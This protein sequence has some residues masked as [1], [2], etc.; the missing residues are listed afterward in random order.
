MKKMKTLYPFSHVGGNL[1]SPTRTLRGIGNPR[2]LAPLVCFVFTALTLTSCGDILDATPDGRLSSDDIYADPELTATQFST[3]FNY[4]P[5][6]GNRGCYFW[7]NGFWA[8]ADEGWETGEGLADWLPS[9]IN[10]KSNSSNF[11]FNGRPDN[12][13]DGNYWNFYW[14]QIHVIN[15]FLEHI[16]TA[17]VAVESNRDLWHAEALTLRAFFYLQLLKYYGALPIVTEVIPLSYDYSDMRKAPFKECAEQVISDCNEAIAI[18]A[19]PW[20]LTNYEQRMRMTAGIATAIKSQMALF[21]ASPLFNE[22]EDLWQW[23][24]DINKQ[25]LNDLKAHDYELYT[26]LTDPQ[27]FK[28]AYQ[29]LNG[30]RADLS[31]SPRDKETIWQSYFEDGAQ[32]VNGFPSNNCFKAGVVP[33]QEL[34]DAYDMLATGK[35]VLKLDKPYLDEKHLQ[36]NYEED[37]GY[38]PDN[39]YAGRDP[40]LFADVLY[41]GHECYYGPDHTPYKIETYVGGQDQI[42]EVA[43]GGKNT[44][45]GYYKYKTHHP[46]ALPENGEANGCV[47]W[48]RLAE[49]Y[50]N[51]AE[52][53]VE[54]GHIDEA[55]QLVNDIRHR[56][57]FSPSVDIPSTLSKEE[58]RLRVHHERQVELSFQEVRYI[59]TRRWCKPGQENLTEK[60]KTGMRIRKKDDGTF[61]YERFDL[62]VGTEDAPQPTQ[63]TYQPKYLLFPIP[64]SEAT[65]M[66]AV[67]GENWQNPGW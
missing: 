52:C 53:A 30:L 50:L 47:K 5:R 6:G 55:V 58:A 37:S 64:L 40:R 46:L 22:G 20:R 10:G 2:L 62:N 17:A 63:Y 66:T 24:Y 7:T 34:V 44:R 27:T 60:Y 59:D 26:T 14:Q 32:N 33:T 23:A 42:A 18:N 57:G 9:V 56:A 4:L 35:P 3:C 13:F 61:T 65:R 15:D 67:T 39:P 19:M 1:Q 8:I 41:N 51:L 36:P 45:T 16:P 38:D 43:A 21:A 25:C 54:C 11:F 48:F 28:S 12:G 29:E 49:I 31:N